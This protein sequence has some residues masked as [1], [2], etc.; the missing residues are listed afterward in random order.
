MTRSSV[1]G[2][3]VGVGGGSEPQQQHGWM[4]RGRGDG[5]CGFAVL[6]SVAGVARFCR[7]TG[8]AVEPQRVVGAG[9][10]ARCRCRGVTSI[11]EE[12]IVVHCNSSTAALWMLNN[13]RTARGIWTTQCP[14]V[15]ETGQQERGHVLLP[16]RLRKGGRR[17]AAGPDSD[18]TRAS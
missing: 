3:G 10:D 1:R 14:A 15:S 6:Q 2:R 7:A 9:P 5:R 12:R 18:D 13:L 4:G 16:R 17:P 11:N 8:A